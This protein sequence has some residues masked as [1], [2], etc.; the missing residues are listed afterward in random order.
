M[1]QER[2]VNLTEAL[3]LYPVSEQIALEL[4]KSGELPSYREGDADNCHYR[5]PLS[6]ARRV[7]A[8]LADLVDTPKAAEML[9]LSPQALRARV[10]QGKIRAARRVSNAPKSPYLFERAEIV[11]YRA[12][13]A[14]EQ[15]AALRIAEDALARR[16]PAAEAAEPKQAAHQGEP[17]RR[18]LAAEIEYLKGRFEGL[19][20]WREADEIQLRHIL[21]ATLRTL[22]YVRSI[23]KELGLPM[24]LPMEPGPEQPQVNSNGH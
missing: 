8:P 7:L 12:R 6:A 18:D 2:I 23:A 11:S 21:D 9:S 4:L 20:H 17:D 22:A 16:A 24:G 15:A 14:T 19:N 3:R 1:R 10:K 13:I 5:I